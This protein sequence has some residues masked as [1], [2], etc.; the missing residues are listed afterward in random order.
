MGAAPALD[1]AQPVAAGSKNGAVTNIRRNLWRRREGL[2]DP[3]MLSPN[4]ASVPELGSSSVCIASHSGWRRNEKPA[5]IT[6]TEA[7][8]KPSEIIQAV[9]EN[10]TKLGM[11]GA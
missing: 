4:A 1:A 8:K 7:V 2:A 10:R 5:S 6:K 11:L 9:L 3:A